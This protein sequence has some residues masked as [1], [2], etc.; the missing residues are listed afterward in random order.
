MLNNNLPAPA[1]NTSILSRIHRYLLRRSAWPFEHRKRPRVE[2]SLIR[3]T[4]TG[5]PGTTRITAERGVMCR[6]RW[7]FMAQSSCCPRRFL[8]SGCR[9][10]SCRPP[11]GVMQDYTAWQPPPTTSRRPAMTESICS[12]SREID[13]KVHQQAEQQVAASRSLQSSGLRNDLSDHS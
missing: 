13:P 8:P 1:G 12:S 4:T 3:F 5:K 2:P 7:G 9:A 6:W 11:G 10:V